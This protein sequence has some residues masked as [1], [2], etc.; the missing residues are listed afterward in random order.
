MVMVA[1]IIATALR[2]KN[3]LLMFLLKLG[4]HVLAYSVLPTEKE[5][6]NAKL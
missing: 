6:K 4:H 2:S 5:G 3:M 1:D